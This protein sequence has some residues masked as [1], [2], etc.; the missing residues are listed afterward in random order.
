MQTRR[1][2]VAIIVGVLV[3]TTMGEPVRRLRLKHT[4]VRPVS[5]QKYVAVE[6]LEKARDPGMDD[7]SR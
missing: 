2:A 3:I 4:D 7:D 6:K 5:M 1:D